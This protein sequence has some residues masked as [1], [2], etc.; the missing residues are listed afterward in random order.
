[1]SHMMREVLYIIQKEVAT[2]FDMGMKTSKK[3]YFL[4]NC[5]T[6]ITK[7]DM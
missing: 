4:V 2:L 5:I 7:E 1:M 6:R 3:M